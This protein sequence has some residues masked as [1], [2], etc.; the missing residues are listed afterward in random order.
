MV[1]K[2]TLEQ[3][4]E[5][6]AISSLPDSWRRNWAAAADSFPNA[7]AIPFL[8]PDY[9]HSAGQ[10]ARL[11]NDKLALVQ[12]TA[13]FIAN[14]ANLVRLAWL[15]H[16][17]LFLQPDY[18]GERVGSW[19]MPASFGPAIAA[20]FP[21]V[22]LLSGTT[23]LKEI[24]SIR[25]IPSTIVLD[26]MW[27]V[28]NSMNL[29]EER[30]GIPGL[31]TSFLGW[32]MNHYNGELY[33]LGR[34]QFGIRTFGH[35][36]QAFR[37]RTDNRIIALS[38]PGIT[39]R[40][41]GLV[42]GTNDIYD[43]DNKWTA[44]LSVT[45]LLIT[46]SPISSEGYASQKTVT[47]YKSEWEPFLSPGDYVYD[48]HIPADGKLTQELYNDSYERA[49]DFFGTYFPEKAF[50]AYTCF[51]WLLDPQLSMLLPGSSNIVQFQRDYH[52]FPIGGGDDSF[53]NFLFKCNKCPV[54]QLPELSTMQKT[55]KNYM[56]A[57]GHMRAS[58]GFRLLNL[59]KSYT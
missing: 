15:W 59:R 49:I 11:P 35:H 9:I 54:D 30:N 45:E 5:A 53:F 52:L 46:G 20:M 36:L 3:L 56:L 32:L 31:G 58:G 26:T 27:D 34:L 24:Y 42:D 25:N 39:Y 28:N 16:Y 38:A 1:N 2:L 18:K 21:A 48:A 51:S 10:F 29:Y 8:E 4:T 17:I 47:L 43:P 7:S 40:R 22:V 13:A 50:K 44:E 14:D 37:N 19:P 23:R 41:D 6:L 57:G 33:R 12:E 55:I